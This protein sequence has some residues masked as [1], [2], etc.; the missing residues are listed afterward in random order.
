VVIVVADGAG[1]I[2]D[3]AHAAETVIREVTAAASLQ[4]EAEAWCEILRQTDC[5]VGAGQATGV[6]VA[7]SASGIVGVSVGDSNN[8]RTVSNPSARCV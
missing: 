6:V 3:G 8:N 5:R 4:H 1:G 2:G 7:R